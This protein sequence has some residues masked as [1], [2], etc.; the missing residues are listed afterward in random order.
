[1]RAACGH[2]LTVG[3]VCSDGIE[4]VRHMHNM[5]PRAGLRV[6]EP[7][8]ISAAIVVFVMQLDDG[9]VF[10]KLSDAFEDPLSNLRM[11]FHQFV[12]FRREV[13]G[14]LQ[15]GIGDTDL[16]ISCSCAP[17]RM[18]SISSAGS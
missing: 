7:V 4:N 17:T 6:P 15:D 10:L 13:A 14:L 12:F 8:G 2:G 5:G 3:A 16:P 1:M 18:T 11:Q 9:K